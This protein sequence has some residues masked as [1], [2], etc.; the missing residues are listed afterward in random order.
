[1]RSFIYFV[2]FR[3]HVT[4]GEPEGREP[5]VSCGEGSADFP[6]AWH[7]LAQHPRLGSLAKGARVKDG[8]YGRSL[9][10]WPGTGVIDGDQVAPLP[11]PARHS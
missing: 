10:R 3:E 9:R 2:A 4:K 1:M 6:Q 11:S 7:H 8:R 5:Q